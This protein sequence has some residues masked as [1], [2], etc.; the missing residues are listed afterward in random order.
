MEEQKKF[1]ITV[2]ATTINHGK[3]DDKANDNEKAT[4]NLFIEQ[5]LREK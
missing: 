3:M 5:F 1:H 4:L 2:Q